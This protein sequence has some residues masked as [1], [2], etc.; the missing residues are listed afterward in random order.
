MDTQSKF[1]NNKLM[2]LL[3]KTCIT[4]FITLKIN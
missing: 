1:N 2:V 3:K 4:I